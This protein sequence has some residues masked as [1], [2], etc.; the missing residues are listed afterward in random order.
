[1]L[2][3]I[4]H[5]TASI[6]LAAIITSGQV[7]AQ[8]KP[9]DDKWALVIG[10]SKFKD[11]SLN[12]KYPA[13][14]AHD[15][16]EYLIKEANFKSDHVKLITDE[17]ATRSN[18]L[19]ELGD[20]WLPKVAHP[21]DLV[22]IYISSHG[23]PSKM[24]NEGCNYLVA[25]DTNR[26]QLYGTGLSLQNLSNTIKERVHSDRILV[27]LDACH[28]GSARAK[29]GGK[30]MFRK[31]NF[32]TTAFPMG[33]GLILVCSSEPSQ[34]SWESKKYENG[35]FTKQL[36]E[37][38]KY[39]GKYTKLGE[40]FNLMKKNVQTEVLNDRGELQTP[41]IKSAWKGDDI[42]LAS[43]PLSPRPGIKQP[44]LRKPSI[45]QTP[46]PANSVFASST[47]LNSEVHNAPV[48]TT[49]SAIGGQNIAIKLMDR[50]AILPVSG[51]KEFILKG[52]WKGWAE[53]DNIDV[54]RRYREIG[55][56]PTIQKIFQKELIKRLK[57]KKEVILLKF[58]DIGGSQSAS[59]SGLSPQNMIN[60]NKLGRMAQAKYLLEITVH[61][62]ELE[63]TA[64]GDVAAARVSAR[65]VSGENG[66]VLWMQK[67]R[68]YSRLTGAFHDDSIFAEMRNFLPNKIAKDLAKPI[69]KSVKDL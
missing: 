25:H 19:T 50:V 34:V 22:V 56:N 69:A 1:M 27:I 15:F 17:Q 32:D 66:E 28:S 8:S 35:V 57:K 54:P 20:R 2:K 13:K 21:N 52:S 33:Q 39:R 38:L 40:A 4:F 3:K 10:I 62:V 67:R 26:K 45:G 60:W 12:L 48:A 7:L 30:G 36:I 47:P 5:L 59:K 41:V 11:Q 55:V 43:K 14:D 16:A 64:Y 31:G 9:V 37:G 42:I 49:G 63:D 58:D 51:P 6:L 53:K 65:L 29:T 44:P 46:Q 61:N 68:K 23:S 24:D 18:I